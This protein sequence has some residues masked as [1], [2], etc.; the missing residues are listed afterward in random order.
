MAKA[1]LITYDDLLRYSNMSGNVDSDKAIQYVSI[2]QDIH[3]QR[4]LGTDLLEKIQSDIIGS[5]L[6]GNYLSLV[7]NWVKPALIHWT[8]VELL[9]MISVTIGNGGIYRHAPENA[10]TLSSEE[11]DSLVS[12][13]RDFAVYYSNRLVDYLCNNSTL[14]PEYNSN[15]NE[16][17]NPSTDNNFCSWVL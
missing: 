2:S 13:E 17:V 4:L 9:P 7:T 12:Q 14:F 3:V 1:L 6:S 10:N 16:D 8:L 5:T 11:V 15:T